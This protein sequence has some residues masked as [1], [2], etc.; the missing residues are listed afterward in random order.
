LSLMID[1]RSIL[2]ISSC[3]LVYP[4]RHFVLGYWHTHHIDED[5]TSCNRNGQPPPSCS[6]IEEKRDID[7][8]CI[9]ISSII[10]HRWFPPWERMLCLIYIN[11]LSLSLV[12][13][14]SPKTRW[15]DLIS[16]WQ[17]VV[18]LFVYICREE[19]KRKKR[20]CQ[21]QTYNDPW[22]LIMIISP[23]DDR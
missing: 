10:R 12:F 14:L 21:Q 15:I 2:L 19:K 3:L 17:P 23:I 4:M 11:Q 18:L 7:L 16:N 1:W 9:S 20:Y 5:K 8:S 22:L 13:S 6:F